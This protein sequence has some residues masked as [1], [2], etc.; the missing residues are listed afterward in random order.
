MER[1][2]DTEL[3]SNRLFKDQ[4]NADDIRREFGSE[5]AKQCLSAMDQFF[6][7]S[8]GHYNYED[9]C[10]SLYSTRV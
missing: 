5:K 2:V 1:H 10:Q 4:I 8:T 6:D 3:S 7:H 9:F